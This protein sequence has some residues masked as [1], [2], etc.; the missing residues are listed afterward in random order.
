MAMLQST[1]T[2]SANVTQRS[3]SGDGS[4]VFERFE[5]PASVKGSLTM[6][7]SSNKEP[8]DNNQL[9]CDAVT[10]TGTLYKTHK[11]HCI[12]LFTVLAFLSKPNQH[13]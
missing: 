7:S 12:I 11:L 3:S 2:Y 6:V 8:K 13:T 10:V 9:S 4:S 1:T 5:G